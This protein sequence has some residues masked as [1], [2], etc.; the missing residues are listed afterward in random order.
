MTQNLIGLFN[1]LILLQ[2]TKVIASHADVFRRSGRND[3][4]RLRTSAWEA[5]KV[6]VLVLGQTTGSDMK[7]REGGGEGERVATIR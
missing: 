7:K 5:T 3:D 6:T 2:L 1:G 4:E